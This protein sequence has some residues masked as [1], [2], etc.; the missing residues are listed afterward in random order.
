M[1]TYLDR[2]HSGEC[3]Q[4]WSELI[5]SGAA[6]RDEPL[7]TD[8][9]AVARE[10][11]RRARLNIETLIGRLDLFCAGCCLHDLLPI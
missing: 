2:Y 6:I 5:A 3:Q 8:A 7:P 11:M 1:S 4:V 9:V 10:T